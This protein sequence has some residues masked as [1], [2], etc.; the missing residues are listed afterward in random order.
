M[1]KLKDVL[2]EYILLML[3]DV[4]NTS[5]LNYGLFLWGIKADWLKIVKKMA[6][7]TVIKSNFIAFHPLAT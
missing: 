2:P 5:R 3:Y 7:R 4:F 1:Y 6:V